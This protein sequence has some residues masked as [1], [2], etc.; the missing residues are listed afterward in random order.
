VTEYI[1]YDVITV[2]PLPRI[3][4]GHC[5]TRSGF[6]FVCKLPAIATD[7]QYIERKKLVAFTPRGAFWIREGMKPRRIQAEPIVWRW[8][9]ESMSVVLSGLEL[10]GAS[11]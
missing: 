4:N 11:Q 9:Q 5:L 1:G 7:L 6:K 3:E 8:K 10:A 2:M